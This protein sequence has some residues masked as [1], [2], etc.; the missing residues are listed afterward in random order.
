MTTDAFPAKAGPT[1]YAHAVSGTGFSR[2]EA[3]LCTPADRQGLPA[4]ANQ[5]PFRHGRT[6][7]DELQQNPM[8]QH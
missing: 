2:E 4:N 3:S 6:Y 8:S 7:P 5:G 1:G